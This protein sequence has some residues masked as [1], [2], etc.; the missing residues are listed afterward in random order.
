[1][2]LKIKDGFGNMLKN[3]EKISKEHKKDRQLWSKE[4]YFQTE[5][6]HYIVCIYIKSRREKKEKRR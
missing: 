3:Y 5:K 1:M 4:T 2:F 6:K